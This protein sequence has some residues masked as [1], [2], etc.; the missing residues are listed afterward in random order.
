MA[1]VAACVTVCSTYKLTTQGEV[2]KFTNYNVKIQ[3]SQVCQPTAQL[4]QSTSRYCFAS[5]LTTSQCGIKGC[6][7]MHQRLSYTQTDVNKSGYMRHMYRRQA[8]PV[9]QLGLLF[10]FVGSTVFLDLPCKG[11]LSYGCTLQL[12]SPMGWPSIFAHHLTCRS[13]HFSCTAYHGLPN[14][15]FMVPGILPSLP[16]S[17]SMGRTY[18]ETKPSPRPE[19][20]RAI[21]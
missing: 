2:A 20:L 6:G 21:S 15:S 14:P 9:I 8:V 13:G 12:P 17:L 3:S 11:T 4:T 16:K 1:G 10:N 19:Q 7:R 18:I 5:L